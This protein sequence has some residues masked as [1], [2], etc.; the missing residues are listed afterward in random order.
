MD[1]TGIPKSKS[2]IWEKTLNRDQ[3]TTTTDW[4]DNHNN[5]SNIFCEM[6]YV[7]NTYIMKK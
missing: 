5:L 2:F 4:D 7:M 3:P 6:T 1:N